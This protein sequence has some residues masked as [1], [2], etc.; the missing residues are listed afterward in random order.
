MCTNSGAIN[1]NTIRYRFPLPRMDDSMDCLS[2][3]KYS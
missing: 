2:G 3:A 1:K